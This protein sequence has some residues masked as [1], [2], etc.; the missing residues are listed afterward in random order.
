MTWAPGHRYD[1][2]KDG[3]HTWEIFDTTTGRTVVIDGKR[4]CDLPLD[5]ADVMVDLMNSEGMEP[6]EERLH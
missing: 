3:E 4:Y 1:I 6:D 5:S 2:R